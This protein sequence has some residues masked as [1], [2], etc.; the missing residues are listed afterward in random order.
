MKR[1][2]EY[3]IAAQVWALREHGEVGPRTFRA[4]MARFGNLAAILEA[5]M[6]DL[7]RIEGLAEKRAHKIMQ[8]FHSLNK[9]EK[10]VTTLKDREIGYSTVFDDDYPRLFTELN[11]PPPII[12][13]RGT[14]PALDE[15]A[16]AL[17]GSHK[18][19]GDGIALA[20]ELASRLA[21]RSVAVVSGLARGIDTAAHIGAVKGGGKTYA[22]I[23]SGLDHIYPEE[24]ITLVSEIVRQGAVISEYPP[25]TT[26][27]DGRLISR[28]R[29]TVGL[30]QAVIVGEIFG[31]SAGT[32]DS[33]AFCH[34]LGKLMFI[35]VDGC[36]TPG[37]DN[38]GVEKVLAM[39]AIP[40]TLDNGL[41]IILKSLV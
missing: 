4:L 20:V 22:L 32:L 15:K 26:Y 27:S 10:F 11:D 17:V 41:D 31:D 24:N 36:D 30:S 8:S 35:L 3:S 7:L 21:S 25:D 2:A 16:V 39:G 28:N 23:G 19:T 1:A 14:L 5:E 37:K 6:E 33:A 13:Y 18:A 29:L 9:S 40:I 34:E 38:A 12:F